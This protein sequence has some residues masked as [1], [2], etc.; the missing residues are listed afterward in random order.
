MKRWYLSK[1]IAANALVLALAY[2]FRYSGF[3]VDPLWF[4]WTIA[5]IN[6][7]LRLITRHALT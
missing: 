1:T 4:V 5:L 3:Y 6:I 2:W 7:G